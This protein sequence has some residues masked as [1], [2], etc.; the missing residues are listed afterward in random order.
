MQASQYMYTSWKNSPN[1]GFGTY[2][3][4]TDITAEEEVV[5]SLMMKYRPPTNLPYEPTEEEIEK[6]FPRVFGYFRL[7][8]GRYCMAQSV[9][10]GHEYKGFEDAGRM[11]NFFI[12]AY[13]FDE[14]PKF[15]AA[16]FIGSD[17]FRRDLTLEE[18]RATNP[19]PLPKVDIPEVGTL[20]MQEL[21]SFL[22]DGSR[23][24]MLKTMVQTAIERIPENKPIF[25]NDKPEN[26][27]M[28]FNAISL[29]MPAD[30]THKITF[31]M[32][33]PES[34]LM[35]V[36]I[37]PESKP[38]FTNISRDAV[39]PMDYKREQLSGV[40][41]FDFSG[42]LFSTAAVGE[43]VSQAVE[44]I[45]RDPFD[46]LNFVSDVTGIAQV[47]G[48]DFDKSTAV[49]RLLKR[50]FN[51]PSLEA[52][53]VAYN[54]ALKYR[55][56]DGS[57][58]ANS[59]CAKIISGAYPRD[60]KLKEFCRSIYPN[61]ST[62]NRNSV[63]E[64]Y[65]KTYAGNPYNCDAYV[66]GFKSE[67]PYPF[68]DF[69]QY[70]F[71]QNSGKSYL[72]ANGGDVAKVYL[73]FCGV[74]ENY[75]SLSQTFTQKDLN[76]F[77]VDVVAKYAQ[78]DDRK[79]VNLFINCVSSRGAS[80]TMFAEKV[81]DVM[82]SKGLNNVNREWLFEV[83]RMLSAHPEKVAGYLAEYVLGARN[84]QECVKIYLSFINGGN[85]GRVNE[86]LRADARL[87]QFFVEVDK[88]N[89]L[90]SKMGRDELLTFYRDYYLK[91]RDK[92]GY[93]M[94]N[95]NKYIA[96][97]PE[98]KRPDESVAMYCMLTRLN[99][100]MPQVLKMLA[101]YAINIPARELEVKLNDP[102]RS[103]NYKRLANDA[104]AAQIGL[105]SYFVALQ[106]Q[107]MPKEP[108]EEKRKSK[109]SADCYAKYTKSE[110]KSPISKQPPVQGEEKIYVYLT[111][112][113]LYDEFVKTYT[114]RAVMLADGMVRGGESIKSAF[115][116][117]FENLSRARNFDQ[118]LV[119]AVKEVA[120]DFRSF[121][122]GDF[123]GMFVI[124]AATY[125][126]SGNKVLQKAATSLLD[127]DKHLK[128]SAEKYA[129]ELAN[130]ANSESKS[131]QK[132]LDDYNA[133]QKGGFF[134]NFSKLFNKGG[135]KDGGNR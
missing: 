123:A 21:T 110:K 83:L 16:T 24:E 130:D 19:P 1:F 96:G 88:Y 22:S 87:A 13:V 5:I 15:R 8:G 46:G 101:T 97:L 112:P 41:V 104:T 73:L 39:F 6:L 10:I 23:K 42:N 68:I 52:L 57:A 64:Y 35:S 74:L 95:L 18:W 80:T 93:F 66:E 133:Q 44:L 59:F 67:I 70:Y 38:L 85:F 89:L 108:Q 2:S 127:S 105:K 75:R 50:D 106:G 122:E 17:I 12:H 7:P 37:P 128:K 78:A 60:E 114:D 40:A 132:F 109:S 124:Y 63:V 71:G 81:A 25:I 65:F 33:T 45:S 58:F 32:L 90:N 55:G 20:S 28:W 117:V 61:M 119:D 98:D 62:Q 27:P 77:L 54:D 82:K 31:I 49:R 56:F 72:S 53:N 121:D 14:N 91:G 94:T 126:K 92:E 102:T 86:I 79:T 111:A 134:S 29:A 36:R 47:S 11:G 120:H 99:P 84:V 43:Y 125:D 30:L 100:L 116:R 115:E 113:E 129:K 69:V 135:K 26:L 131:V 76:D 51:F 9:Y 107:L 48:L 34:K 103:E 3:K 118:Y 4:S